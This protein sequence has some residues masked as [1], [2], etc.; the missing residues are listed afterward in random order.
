[1]ACIEMLKGWCFLTCSAR[2]VHCT[3]HGLN[4][5]ICLVVPR[6]ACA[7]VGHRDEALLAAA[8]ARLQNN[9]GQLTK[10]TTGE[11]QAKVKESRQ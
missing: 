6:R 3:Q 8:T 11:N 10:D 4:A 9:V 7:V 2:P 1:M 5:V